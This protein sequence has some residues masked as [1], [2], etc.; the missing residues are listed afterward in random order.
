MGRFQAYESLIVSTW[1]RMNTTSISVF[2]YAKWSENHSV[3]S[4]SLQPDVLYSP[5]N[6]LGQNTGVSSLSLLQGIFP[7]QGLNPGLHCR[8]ILYQLS[9]K[10]SPWHLFFFPDLYVTQSQFFSLKILGPVGETCTI[11]FCQE[12]FGRR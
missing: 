8:Q 10:G 12:G 4:D 11:S 1:E 7:T 3:V 2:S 9:H 6:S 5:W